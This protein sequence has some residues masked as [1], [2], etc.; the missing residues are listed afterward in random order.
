MIMEFTRMRFAKLARK[1]FPEA[2]LAELYVK[3]FSH[4]T[5]T[6]LAFTV[7]NIYGKTLFLF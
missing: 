6:V 1:I 3:I 7:T 4:S 2:F 5:F